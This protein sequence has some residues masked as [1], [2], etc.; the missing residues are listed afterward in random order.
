MA[1]ALS[2]ILYNATK[3]LIHSFRKSIEQEIEL[4]KEAAKLRYSEKQSEGLAEPK[5]MSLAEAKLIL[6]VDKLGSSEIEKKSKFL[7][8]INGK[9]N[10]GSFYLQSKVVR[11]KERLDLERIG[12]SNAD[13]NDNVIVNK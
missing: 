7:F 8:E 9:K 10:W 11:A 1:K 3:I 6:N 4:S 2:R 5:Q 12:K 13:N